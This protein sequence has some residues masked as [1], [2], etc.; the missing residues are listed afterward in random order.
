MDIAF[1]QSAIF[2]IKLAGDITK[3]LMSLTKLSEVSEKVAGIQGALLEAQS[4]AFNANAKQAAMVEEVRAL[5]EEMAR[6]KAWDTEKQRYKLAIPFPRHGMGSV[7][8][9]LKESMKGS[10]PAHLICTKCYED[11]RKSILNPLKLPDGKS[12]VFVCPVCQA[13]IPTGCFYTAP[14]VSYAAG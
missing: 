4:N 1:I 12:I 5:K 2:S 3:S 6:L 14:P 11:G 8:Y 10:E 9:A 7:A 13:Q